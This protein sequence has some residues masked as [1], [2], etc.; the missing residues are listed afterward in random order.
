MSLYEKLKVLSIED[1][2]VKA[3]ENAAAI[4]AEHTNP[5][6]W[7][8]IGHYLPFMREH[9]KGTI[10]EIGVRTGASTSA[11]LL[12]LEE[13]DGHL[14]SVDIAD[15]SKLFARH[16]KWTFLQSDS[17]DYSKVIT[18]VPTEVDVLFIDGDHS[19]EGYLYDLKTYSQFV[20]SGGLIISHDIDPIPGWTIEEMGPEMGVGYPSK[21]IREEYFKFAEAHGYEHT[22]LPGRCGMGVMVKK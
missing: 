4:Y 2:I 17:K 10:F 11:F 3:K 9:A 5:D 19:R 21:A 18:V 15:C 8:D 13:N 6:F 20:K 16:P 12:G 14:Y 7:S 1:Q 22:E